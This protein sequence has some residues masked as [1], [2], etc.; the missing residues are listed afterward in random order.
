MWKCRLSLVTGLLFCQV[1]GS[2]SVQFSSVAQSSPTLCDPMNCNTP[3]FLV[4]QP[5]PGDCSN[6]CPWSWWCHTTISSS[7]ITFSCFQSFPALGSFPVS[8][9][10]TSSGQSMGVSA[11]AS[12]LPM[13][14]QNWF[15]LGL[16]DLSPRDSQE[17]CPTPQFKSINS[18]VLSFLYSP[19]LTSIH[20]YW[21]IH[22]F[23][24][25]DL[26]WQNVEWQITSVFLPWEPHEQWKRVR[27]IV[28]KCEHKRHVKESK[29]SIFSWVLE[30][31]FKK[32][33]KKYI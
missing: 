19:T 24:W 26:C 30:I 23:D 29:Q 14:I 28:I 16:T 6:S 21:K 10:F 12:V 32:R 5:T 7:V 15:P 20:D 18:S 11:S 33:L 1:K 27:I 8:Q 13:N 31:W 9:F 4:Y 22:S 17:S 2:A 3:G 25:M